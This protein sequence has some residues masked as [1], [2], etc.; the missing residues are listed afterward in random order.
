MPWTESLSVNI[1][2][3]DAEHKKL[4]GLLDDLKTALLQGKTSDVMSNTL[5]ELIEYTK[6]H[7]K[8]EEQALQEHGYPD[9]ELQKSQHEEFITKVAQIKHQHFDYDDGR[10][11]G[12][13]LVGALNSWVTNHIMKTDLEYARFLNEKGMR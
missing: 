7:F 1:A 2:R 5:E 4:I 8:G 3:F 9:L 11:V 12:L 10:T 13:S 6:T